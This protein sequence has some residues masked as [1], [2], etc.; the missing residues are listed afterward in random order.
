VEPK[1]EVV[2]LSR[3]Q[4]VHHSISVFIGLTLISVRELDDEWLV[5]RVSYVIL[6]VS[7]CRMGLSCMSGDFLA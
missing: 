5:V 3:A 1:T 6:S 7:I 2:L 4:S